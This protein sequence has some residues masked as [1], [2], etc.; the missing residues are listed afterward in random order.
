MRENRGRRP[1]VAGVDG[2]DSAMNAVRWAALEARRRDTSLRLVAACAWPEHHFGSEVMGIDYRKVMVRVAREQLADAARAAVEAAAEVPV[3]QQVVI[4]YPIPVLVAESRLAELVVVGSRGLGGISGLVIGSVAVGLAQQADSPVVVVRGNDR[5]VADSSLPVVVGVDGSPLS[6]AALG[7]AFEAASR[8]Q[9]KLAAVLATGIRAGVRLISHRDD[10]QVL[11]HGERA[12]DEQLAGWSE[13]F[14]TV[15]VLRVVSRLRPVEELL[16]KAAS[17]QLVVVGSRGRGPFTGLIGSV[18][19]ALLLRS[20]C[21]V[22][23]VRPSG[24][25]DTATGATTGPSSASTAPR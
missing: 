7:F 8:R 17:A 23:V 13:K 25:I 2:S 4:S 16:T 15:P 6:Q 21:P 10:P 19:H 24:L 22:A 9:V 1:V 20:Q 12:L 3:E 11:D 14:P 5:A 18:S